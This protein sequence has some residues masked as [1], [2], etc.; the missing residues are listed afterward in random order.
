VTRLR[1]AREALADYRTERVQRPPNLFDPPA[2]PYL[3]SVEN[4]ASTQWMDHAVRAIRTAARIH[5]VLTV[6]EVHAHLSEPVHDMRALGAAMRRA[7]REH[8]IERCP[9]EYRV[10]LRSETHRRP[11]AVWKSRIFGSVG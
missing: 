3:E 6:D 10:S 8:V 7:A 1:E 11:L 9:G 5:P 2:A 4:N